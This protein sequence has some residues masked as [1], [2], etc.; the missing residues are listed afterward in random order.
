MWVLKEQHGRGQNIRFEDMW[1]REK[2]SNTREFVQA[3]ADEYVGLAIR[4]QCEANHEGECSVD[5][6]V[7]LR[8]A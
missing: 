5:Y 4:H 1:T 2:K 8:D 3:L 6:S 7:D